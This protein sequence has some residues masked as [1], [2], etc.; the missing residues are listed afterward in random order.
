MLSRRADTLQAGGP[1]ASLGTRPPRPPLPL[2]VGWLSR[3]L[4]RD[5][6]GIPGE[7]LN[8]PTLIRA[9]VRFPAWRLNSALDV[10][11]ERL[12]DLTSRLGGRLNDPREYPISAQNAQGPTTRCARSYPFTRYGEGE[13]DRNPKGCEP[14]GERLPRTVNPLPL[15]CTVICLLREQSTNDRRTKHFDFAALF[16]HLRS[17]F[18]VPML[19]CRNKA[20]YIW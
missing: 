10:A 7:R 19:C 16:A 13:R 17:A 9:C 15:I 5:C 14:E 18:R 11:T 4:I 1:C 3:T 20:G 6:F 12:N 8:E 2:N